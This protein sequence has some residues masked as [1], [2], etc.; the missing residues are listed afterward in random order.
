MRFAFNSLA[1]PSRLSFLSRGVSTLAVIGPGVNIN[2]GLRVKSFLI[3]GGAF[4][5]KAET[6]D[7]L[8]SVCE[9]MKL[10]LKKK[11]DENF[12][13]ILVSHGHYGAMKMG[14]QIYPPD[15]ID[16][17][18]QDQELQK[19]KMRFFFV[20]C[21]IGYGV[22]IASQTNIINPDLVKRYHDVLS[23]NIDVVLCGDEKD[24]P[25][26]TSGILV[27]YL[28]D[29]EHLP[30]FDHIT[31]CLKM[32][33]PFKVLM[34]GKSAP[35]IF[36]HQ[37]FE[38]KSLQDLS[39]D[40]C[41]GHIKLQTR[42][43]A[44]FCKNQGLPDQDEMQKAVDNVAKYTTFVDMQHYLRHN[45]LLHLSNQNS[46]AIP[47]YYE[48]QNKYPIRGAFDSNFREYYMMEIVNV[49]FKLC[50]EREI[51][52]IEKMIK[53]GVGIDA[54]DYRGF[55][56]LLLAYQKGDLELFDF[57]L[58]KDANPNHSY[59]ILLD[60]GRQIPSTILEMFAASYSDQK[61]PLKSARSEMVDKIIRSDK[62]ILDSQSFRKGFESSF[63][64][65]PKPKKYEAGLEYVVSRINSLKSKPNTAVESVKLVARDLCKSKTIN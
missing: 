14:S 33:M 37:L 12:R 9:E 29:N 2:T 16:Y 27:K 3:S 24:S 44:E 15:L 60:D 36:E 11:P 28:I 40:K 65:A 21:K 22:G 59:P 13:L 43:F 4:E 54:R 63:G 55:N 42:N 19:V 45:F 35:E 23:E 17:L 30:D 51:D 20:A 32:P 52:G 57:L 38:P 34:P 31:F 61:E 46:K 26:D 39:D 56:M 53:G 5:S 18:T 62:F 7:V 50:D 6:F 58:S 8:D 25:I 47:I 10:Q 49:L 48:N 64:E 41:R 1:N